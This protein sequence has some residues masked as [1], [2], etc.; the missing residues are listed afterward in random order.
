[1][2]INIITHNYI[3]ILLIIFHSLAR[4][5][6]LPQSRENIACIHILNTKWF[7]SHKKMNIES[8]ILREELTSLPKA[9]H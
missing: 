6:Y 5:H 7:F 2:P 8:I 1:M 9:S 3:T 4:V